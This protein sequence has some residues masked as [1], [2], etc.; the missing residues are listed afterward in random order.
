M[1]ID[2]HFTDSY[3]WIIFDYDYFTDRYKICRLL[4]CNA[5]SDCHLN[6]HVLHL[7]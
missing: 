2:I 1:T 6:S 5:V 3:A 7:N 4:V